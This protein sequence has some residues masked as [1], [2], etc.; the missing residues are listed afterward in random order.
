[1]T[2]E[3]RIEELE[4]RER[5]LR[6][7]FINDE[8]INVEKVNENGEKTFVKINPTDMDNYIP[9]YRKE[10]ELIEK[11]LKKL[12]VE[13]A[14]ESGS[15][16]TYHYVENGQ[17]GDRQ[18]T[19]EN[20][21]EYRKAYE[22]QIR[23]IEQGR[24]TTDD[25]MKETNQNVYGQQEMEAELD[26]M[27]DEIHRENPYTETPWQRL[28]P[29]TPEPT[30]SSG[31]ELTPEREEE[32]NRLMTEILG[33]NQQTES[34][35][36]PATKPV[37]ELTP[38]SEEEYNKIMDEIRRNNQPPETPEP[39][40]GP[41]LTP[42]REEEYN[43][44]MN[45]I[46]RNNQ[47]PQTEV[48]T[49]IFAQQ[50]SS[51]VE[52]TT[53][54]TEE[55]AVEDQPVVA[56]EEP[57]YEDMEDDELQAYLL[58][59]RE[60]IKRWTMTDE[61]LQE[62]I[63]NLKQGGYT[64]A[65]I[66][67]EIKATEDDLDYYEAELKKI[68]AEIERRKTQKDEIDNDED[69]EKSPA[70]MT[71]EELKEYIENHRVWLN[72]YSVP[73]NKQKDINDLKTAN[74]GKTDE[75]IEREIEELH[76]IM[77]TELKEAEKE[78]EKRKTT[79]NNPTQDS[80]QTT[81][82]KPIVIFESGGKVFVVGDIAPEKVQEEVR[83]TNSPLI[84][85]YHGKY[86]FSSNV[87]PRKHAYPNTNVILTID[88]NGLFKVEG[89]DEVEYYNQPTAQ[90]TDDGI[91]GF[92]DGLGDLEEPDL[93]V[94]D[95]GTIDKNPIIPP[96]ARKAQ[97]REKNEE[98]AKKF[99]KALLIVA[100]A[101]LAMGAIYLFSKY[102]LDIDIIE[103]LRHL[104]SGNNTPADV[105]PIAKHVNSAIGNITNHVGDTVKHFSNGGH[106][107]GTIGEFISNVA[108]TGQDAIQ[109]ARGASDVTQQVVAIGDAWAPGGVSG[110]VRVAGDAAVGGTVDLNSVDT[111][112]ATLNDAINGTNG[113]P[114]SEYARPNIVGVY[115]QITGVFNTDTLSNVVQGGRVI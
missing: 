62:Y 109:S 86:S 2:Y 99:K 75:E 54:S 22:Q 95:I 67:E 97:S 107:N 83:K 38:E 14:Y 115:D 11:E 92:D 53:E 90:K 26:R 85:K 19:S 23:F 56:Y 61:E 58:N 8:P 7:A 98:L 44:I 69:D 13:T 41:E 77:R 105:T 113:M 35:V 81:Q 60:R 76:T 63:E 45:E 55:P 57:N 32:Y 87:E 91:K 18:V 12:R 42:E 64:E 9:S 73:E 50:P 110:F 5:E 30:V 6:L 106:I 59:C 4:K 37:P 70:E 52:S 40:L 104:I 49:D 89:A 108:N 79:S 24:Q 16:L 82:S 43:K 29:E 111:V 84:N 10:K 39:I 68:E 15:P 33:D 66:K 27:I 25:L 100:G 3:E 112:Y 28:T 31:P 93:D 20:K 72:F 17:E 47:P 36:E 21:D 65:E 46:H 1:M 88:E 78:E 71:D 48:S 114:I 96:T 80:A 102:A 103:N 51:I 34:V 101:A 74:P 94:S